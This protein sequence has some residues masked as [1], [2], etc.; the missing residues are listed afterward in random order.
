MLKLNTL[1]TTMLITS[2]AFAS[3][4]VVISN[5]KN[6]YSSA[7]AWSIWSDVG[8][9][10][11]CTTP[12]PMI[13]EIQYGT[14]FV[15]YYECTQEKERTRIDGSDNETK[16]V[17]VQHNE[18]LTGTYL[19]KSCNDIL[20]NGNGSNSGVYRIGTVESNF[21]VY[22]KMEDNIGWTLVGKSMPGNGYRDMNELKT[23]LIDGINTNNITN[24]NLV[25]NGKKSSLG[26]DKIKE[27]NL[28]GI[29]RFEF[30][31]ENNYA[32]TAN[33]YKEYTNTSFR[34]WYNETETTET[35]TCTNSSLSENCTVDK[36]LNYRDRYWF[37]G[38][39]LG[40]YGYAAING[41]VFYPDAFINNK[42]LPFHVFYST[43]NSSY[44]GS[45][46]CS[47]TQ[48]LN[49]NAWSD[50][51]VDGQWGNALRIYLK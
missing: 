42:T 45:T 16:Y 29:A 19:D 43:D 13:D 23:W 9:E 17:K 2:S 1:I 4:K 35:L 51:A 50:S 34:Q 21:E 20:I 44:I 39:D 7:S 40:K 47:S 15:Q 12:S 41:T 8:Q 49:N 3:Y 48:D 25:Y 11:D 5:D 30:V 36:F 26:Y 37:T 10:Y 32:Q 22:C 38:M 46:I 28:S 33:F 24:E 14:S 27:M 31:A 6:D 18:T